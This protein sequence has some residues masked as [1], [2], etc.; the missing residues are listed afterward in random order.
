M[1][2]HFQR[3]QSVGQSVILIFVG[4]V[5]TIGLIAD[6][7]TGFGAADEPLLAESAACFV[8]GI[9]GIFGKQVCTECGAVK[10]GY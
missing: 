3:E 8:V 7:F 5:V 6:D 9:N 4:V 10:Y 1:R 2:N